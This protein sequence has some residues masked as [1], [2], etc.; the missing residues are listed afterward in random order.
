MA[1]IY[2]LPPNSLIVL[3]LRYLHM[4]IYNYLYVGMI[5]P[6]NMHQHFRK[7]KVREQKHILEHLP[8]LVVSSTYG[9]YLQIGKNP[10]IL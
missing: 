3:Y 1:P 5:C 10:P 6:G 9:N 8:K 7:E 2:L 4:Y